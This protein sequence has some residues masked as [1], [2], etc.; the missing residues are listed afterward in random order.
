MKRLNTIRIVLLAAL[1]APIHATPSWADLKVFACEPEWAA[2]AQEIGGDKVTTYS[3]TTA[4]QDPHQVQA[5]PSL[6]ARLRS[7]DLL[8]CTGAE[9]EA[10]WLPVMLLQSANGAV[11]AGSP[12]YLEAAAMVERLEI[13][14]QVDRAQGDV[15]ASGNPHIQTDPRRIAPVAREVLARMSKLDTANAALYQKRH[16]AFAQKWEQAILRWESAAAPL[17][18]VPVLVY[19]RSWIYLI[20][21]LGIQQVGEL[22]PKPGI[23]PSTAHLNDLINRLKA[24][25]AKMVIRSAYEDDRAAIFISEREKIP[26]VVLPFTVGGTDGAK[27]LFSLYDDT[28]NRL[29][30]AL[31]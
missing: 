2:L 26:A 18:G 7:A 14:G 11:Q 25:P 13:P 27:D 20:D 6:I 23:P 12:G 3:A 21:W 10:G 24:Q 31:K 4:L 9:L 19:H 8:I 15:H 17:K 29:L 28:I 5:R 16:E 30:G 22:E 1:L